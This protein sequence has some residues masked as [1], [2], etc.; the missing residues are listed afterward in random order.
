VSKE[1]A[2]VGVDQGVIH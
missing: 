2:V 1:F